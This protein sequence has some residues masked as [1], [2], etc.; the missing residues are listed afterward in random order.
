M[1]LTWIKINLNT[2][3]FSDFVNYNYYLSYYLNHLYKNHIRINK[4]I[5]LKV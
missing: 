3:D 1:T 5:S 2:N 4:I